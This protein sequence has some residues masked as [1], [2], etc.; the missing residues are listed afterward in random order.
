MDFDSINFEQF[1]MWWKKITNATSISN[2]AKFKNKH[3]H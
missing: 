2:L 3:K 1:E